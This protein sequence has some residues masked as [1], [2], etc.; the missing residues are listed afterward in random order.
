[1]MLD[2]FKAM[3]KSYPIQIQAAGMSGC[4]DYQVYHERYKGTD[5]RLIASRV[6]E[7]QIETLLSERDYARFREGAFRFR[8]TGQQLAETLEVII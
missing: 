1:M 5:T 8:V 7:D 4:N 3:R 6:S 2:G